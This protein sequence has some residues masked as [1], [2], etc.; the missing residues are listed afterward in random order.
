M[1]L[2]IQ[3]AVFDK[4]GLGYKNNLKQKIANNLYKKS[5]SENTICF[6][7]GKTGHKSYICNLRKNS[8]K[9]KFKKVWIIKGSIFTNHE[10]PKN[11]WLPKTT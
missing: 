2:N 1:I 8:S 3:K 5:S 6:C 10:G 4:A 11:T 7:C 9:S